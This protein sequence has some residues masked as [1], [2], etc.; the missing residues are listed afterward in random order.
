MNSEKG[1]LE[2]K[3]HKGAFINPRWGLCVY[4]YIYIYIIVLIIV[5]IIVIITIII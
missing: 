4:I 5:L 2:E 1:R 3:Q